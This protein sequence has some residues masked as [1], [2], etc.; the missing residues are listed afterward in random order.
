MLP[1]LVEF[2]ILIEELDWQTI[3]EDLNAGCAISDLKAFLESFATLGRH[4]QQ[5][6]A[7]GVSRS[8]DYEYLLSEKQCRYSRTGA[9]QTSRLC[10]EG[11]RR[12]R[13]TQTLWRVVP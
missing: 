10:F 1:A 3:E 5:A 8:Q 13:E 6:R 12:N 11:N 9:K 7:K 2:R 4:E